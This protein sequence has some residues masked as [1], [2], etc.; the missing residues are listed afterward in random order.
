MLELSGLIHK[1]AYFFQELSQSKKKKMF[2][3]IKQLLKIAHDI[4]LLCKMS[5]L[6]DLI[7]VKFNNIYN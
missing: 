2:I 3:C 1:V 5:P 4:K 7:F 6:T